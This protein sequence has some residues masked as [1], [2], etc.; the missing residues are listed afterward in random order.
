MTARPVA[1]LLFTAALALAAPGHAAGVDAVQRIPL[2]VGLITVRA[3][4]DTQ[5]DYESI[6]STTAVGSA[7]YSFA[8][9]AE[10]PDGPGGKTREN[11]VVRTVPMADHLHARTMRSHYDGGDPAVFAGT[12]PGVS[13]D[14]V[15]EL[16]GGGRATMTFLD[17]RPIFGLTSIRRLTG[18]VVRVG[19]GAEDV[20]VIVNG[21]R[22]SVRV[23]H[24]KGRLADESGAGELEFHVL[25]DPDNPLM[26][27]TTGPGFTPRLTRIDFPQAASSS[28]SIETKLAANEAV[29]VYGIY[30]AFGSDHLRPESDRVLQ[31]VADLL[32]KH[33]DWKLQVDGHTDNIGGDDANLDLSRRR[34]AAVKTALVQRY[35]IAAPRLDTGGFGEVRPKDRNDTIEGR[36]LNRRVELRRR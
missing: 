20:P 36:A 26:L 16:R 23:L 7:G 13:A 30:F 31:E 4:A 6:R 3:V 17:Q 34:A 10:V 12:T 5:G 33:A 19:A 27:T 8:I 29:D 28:A 1:A 22:A 21:R 9:R 24:A 25:D 32:K 18:T 35:A 14:I 15:K 2:E 11:R